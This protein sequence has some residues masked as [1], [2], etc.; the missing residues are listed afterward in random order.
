MPQALPL[1]NMIGQSSTRT[2][3][4]K[5]LS[6]EFANGY[7]Q[8]APDGINA[9]QDSWA[10]KYENLSSSERGA[11]MAVL[12]AVGSWDYL[13]WQAPGDAS[14]KKWKVSMDGWTESTTG[15]LWSMSF[16]LKQVY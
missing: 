3:K 8:T 1:T 12:D 15:A 14:V 5:T 16:T 10:I 13:T 9:T 11:V 2:R 7:S 6:A 4:Y